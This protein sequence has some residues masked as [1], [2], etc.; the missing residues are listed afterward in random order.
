[1]FYK[2]LADIVVLTHFLWIV[3]LTFGA[4]LGRKYKGVKIFHIA[5]IGFAIL[6]QIF[7]WYCPLTHIEVW[8]REM[9]DPSQ[10]YQGSFIINY[11]EKL[12]YI[13]LPGKTIFIATIFLIL[14]SAWIYLHKSKK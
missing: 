12:V 8:L 5:G 4:F 11:V 1:M 14:M 7:G 9:H 13:Q 6:I 2:I 10:S 3:F